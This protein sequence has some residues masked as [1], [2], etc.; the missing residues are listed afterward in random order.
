MHMH[1]HMPMH[2]HKLMHIDSYAFTLARS[3]SFISAWPPVTHISLISSAL[4]RRDWAM[5][6]VRI[7]SSAILKTLE[8][9]VEIVSS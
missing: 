6:T 1:M 2:M 5:K 3:F 7:C 4:G 9:N 8:I